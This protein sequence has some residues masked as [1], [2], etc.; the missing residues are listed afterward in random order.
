MNFNCNKYYW[1]KQDNLGDIAT[2]IALSYFL[3]FLKFNK[4]EKENLLMFG[5]TIFDHINNAN[6]LYKANFKKIIFFGVGVSKES[7]IDRAIKIIKNNNIKITF[8]P[9]G[10]KTKQEVEKKGICCEKPVG[11]VLQIL[12]YLPEANTDKNKPDLLVLDSY[13]EKLFNIESKNYLTIKVAK[14]KLHPNVPYYDFYNF[15]KLINN[16]NKVYSSQVHPF[17][18]SALVGKPCY[19]YK[20]DWRAEDFKYFKYFNLDMTKED[21][22]NLRHEAQKSS[23][24]LVKRL[25]EKLREFL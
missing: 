15:L 22:L 14:N 16:C 24:K 20:K 17:L 23:H 2:D 6:I 9:R 7:E 12:S 25:L 5:G 8:V 1:S 4:Q 10:Q 11:D 18:I 3:P 21:S 13:N 19:L